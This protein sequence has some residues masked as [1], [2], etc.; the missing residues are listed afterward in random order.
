VT[1]RW[2]LEFAGAGSA[3][4]LACCGDW[5]L[6]AVAAGVVLLPVLAWVRGEMAATRAMLRGFA[7]MSAVL[8][9]LRML[10]GAGGKELPMAP[11]PRSA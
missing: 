9:E 11:T 3:V 8:A 5:A 7:E 4:A 2:W 1:G 10:G 6:A